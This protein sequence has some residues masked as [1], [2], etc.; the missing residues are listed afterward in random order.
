MSDLTTVLVA[1]GSGGLGVAIVGVVG[2]R[3]GALIERRDEHD[4]WLREQRF[5]AN[6][7]YLETLMRITVL[8][9]GSRNRESA[10]RVLELM[11]D[12]AS[13]ALLGPEDVWQ[14]AE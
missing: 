12:V 11:G 2:A 7:A 14:A 3:I 10:A 4:K 8:P 13:L 1:V 9:N 5:I 6:K